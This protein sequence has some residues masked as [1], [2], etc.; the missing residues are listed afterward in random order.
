MPEYLGQLRL[1]AL[2][3]AGEKLSNVPYDITDDHEEEKVEQVEQKDDEPE[4]NVKKPPSEP[5]KIV[6]PQ[7]NP[8]TPQ[9]QNPFTSVATYIHW[10]RSFLF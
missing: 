6:P 1:A 9:A 4:I 8:P 2:N 3:I 10:A 7:T 5:P